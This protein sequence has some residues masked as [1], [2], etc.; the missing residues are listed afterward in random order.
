MAAM[1]A[2]VALVV[3]GLDPQP[4][5]APLPSRGFET[6]ATPAPERATPGE[7][8]DYGRDRLVV[9]SLNI[10]SPVVPERVDA[11]GELVVPGD[12]ATV[13]LWADGPGPTARAGTTVVAGHVDRDGDLGALHPLH[14]IAPNARV[15]LTDAGGRAT[16]WQVV[17]LRAVPKD[18]LPVFATSGPRRL[19]IVTCGGAIIDTPAGRRYADNVIAT[20]V[21]APRGEAPPGAGD[22]AAALPTGALG[23]DAP[24]AYPGGD[25]R[26]G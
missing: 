19:A 4:Q 25:I 6:T 11:S 5:P 7:R 23:A 17:S 22:R 1:V 10:D 12:V 14:R 3:A 9:P 24:R 13:G 20:A 2:G 26:R 21:P 15:V 16:R 18:E 8:A